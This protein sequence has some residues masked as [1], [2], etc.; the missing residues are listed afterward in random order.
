[1]DTRSFL[2]FFFLTLCIAVALLFTWAHLPYGPPYASDLLD[3]STN[4]AW[5]S[6]KNRL[7]SKPPSPTRRLRDH[8]SDTPHHPLDPLTLPEITAVRSILSSHALF[9]SSS[10]HALHSVDLQEPDKSLV[11][12][13][14]HGDPLFPRKATVVAR[15][16]DMSHVLTVD[17]T[18]REVTVEDTASHSGYPTMTLE[19]MTAATWVPLMNADFNRTIVQR[20]VDLTDLACLPLST[21]WYGKV[22]EKRRLIKVQ[23]YSTKD[24]VNFY[25]RPIEG[26]TVLVDLDTKQVL[27]ISDKGGSIP[28]PKA[29]NTDY[30]YSA[31]K[32][33]QVLKLLKPISIEQPNG[34]SFTVE[35]DHLVKWANWEF[36]LKPDARAGVIVSQAKVRDPNTGEFRDV[37][38]KGFTSELFVP[39][40]DPTDAW[41]F[42]TYMDAGEYGFG[43]QAMSLDPLNDC[44]RNAY[45]MDGVFA[46]ADGTPYVRSNMV[47]VFESYAGDIAWRHT[48]CPIT[49]MQIREVRPK[50]T[51]V[52]RMAAS[53]ANYDYIIDWEFQT[54]GLIRVKVGLSGIL[55]VKGTSYENVNQ[56]SSPENLHG[57]LLS[58]NVIGVIHDHYVTFYL[59]MDVDGSDNSFLKVNLR[60]EQNS[61]NESPRKSYLKATKTVAKTEK[62]AQVKLKLYDP[63]EF[64]VIN[65]TK[66]T[67]VGNPVGYKLVPGGTAASL[68][69]LDDPP[70]KRGAFTNNQIWVT[71][72]NRSEQWAGGLLVCQSQGEDT[73]AVW[74]DR[75]R[76]IENKDIVLWYTLG[77]HHIP[78]QEDFPIMPTVSSSFDLKPVNFFESN[79]ILRTPPNVETD[80][81]VCVAAASA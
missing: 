77:F 37:M 6:S 50:V 51:L 27:E 18:T 47:C 31:Q 79:P 42:K 20:G 35:D 4:S 76:P 15:V 25:M 22:E 78:C 75:D 32:P 81:P 17:L 13:W 39:Y 48:E 41:Y 80:L 43:L 62:D 7:Q 21:G 34:R 52:V 58:E 19:E 28:I 44:P 9:A 64:H 65:P 73:L 71:P 23:C 72:Y 33:N 11:L 26:L 1:M 46:A 66:R 54:D 5:C 59:D 70:Q 56:V 74:S 10:S 38:Y 45:Y 60:R 61:P 12:R 30:R 63:S 36:H 29:A 49:G 55:M 69:D 24:T 14:H 40:M 3:C 2:R 53:V 16:D 67:R 57:T 68:L 8:A